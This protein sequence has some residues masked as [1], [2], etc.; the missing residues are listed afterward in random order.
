M[1]ERYSENL[2][3]D[4]IIDY[5][6][7]EYVSTFAWINTFNKDILSAD[8]LSQL[9]SSLDMVY[10]DPPY[11]ERQYS[12]NYFPLN[13]IALTPTQ[14]KEEKPLKGKTGIP[15]SC[16][17]S[18][19]CRKGKTV[20]DAFEKLFKQLDTQWLF[21]SYNSESIVSKEKML[22]LMGK[23]GTATRRCNS[24]CYSICASGA[25]AWGYCTC[26]RVDS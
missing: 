16:F 3:N 24:I 1:N 18:P 19:F 6:N 25:C 7:S 13:M 15:E 14:Q 8:L 23:Y 26:R 12:K 10:L 17:L 9:P 4:L 5:E 22:A 11:N 2:K 21:L 20:E